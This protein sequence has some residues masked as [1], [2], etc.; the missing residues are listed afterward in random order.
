[1]KPGDLVA[2]RERYPGPAQGRLERAKGLSHYTHGVI[3]EIVDATVRSENTHVLVRVLWQNGIQNEQI[4]R[5]FVHY[6][7]VVNGE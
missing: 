7:E 6:Y 1:M 2:W 5:D 3:V 4:L